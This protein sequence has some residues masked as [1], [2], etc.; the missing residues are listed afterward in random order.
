MLTRSQAKK[1]HKEH[2][3]KLWSKINA[4]DTMSIIVS[5]ML[6]A[7]Y[8][9]ATEASSSFMR[10]D[11]F[12]NKFRLKPNMYYPYSEQ[13]PCANLYLSFFTTRQCYRIIDMSWSVTVTDSVVETILNSNISTNTLEVLDLSMC[14]NVTVLPALKIP[15]E[16]S[17]TEKFEWVLNPLDPFY[18]TITVKLCGNIWLYK[19]EYHSVLGQESIVKLFISSML[20]FP[21]TYGYASAALFWNDDLS[22]LQQFCHEIFRISPRFDAV[23]SARYEGNHN[24]NPDLPETYSYVRTIDNTRVDFHFRKVQENNV[25]VL[26]IDDIVTSFTDDIT[27][28]DF[29][30]LVETLMTMF[31][32]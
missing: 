30:F 5:F 32:V 4:S 14:P 7:E 19:P 22:T 8:K 10:R 3:F 20:V 17:M 18:K 23:R 13:K 24:N 15:H 11:L 27:V 9:R 26:K 12:T 16:A 28:Q 1:A 29:G 31:S 21:M 2:K 6:K 25:I